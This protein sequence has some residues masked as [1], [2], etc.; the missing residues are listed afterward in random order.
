MDGEN[1]QDSGSVQ[2]RRGLESVALAALIGS[3]PHG[4]TKSQ[5]RDE[6]T[7]VEHTPERV[8]AIGRAIDGLIEVGLVARRGERLLPTPAALRAG[9]LEL[10][11]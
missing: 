9:E 11:L 5:V 2:R 6:L 7:T 8:A 4:L 3:H 1:T 10:G